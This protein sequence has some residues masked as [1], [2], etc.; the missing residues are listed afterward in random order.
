MPILLTQGTRLFGLGSVDLDLLDM[1]ALGYPFF[2]IGD[3]LLL[4]DL[5]IFQKIVIEKQKLFELQAIVFGNILVLLHVV[6]LVEQVPHLADQLLV[7]SH[8][9]VAPSVVVLQPLFLDARVLGVALV[10]VVHELLDLLVRRKRR[11]L[12]VLAHLAGHL[13]FLGLL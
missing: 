3:L 1:L 11:R 2:Q 6:V 13:L 5:F 4:L 10:F 8:L 7:P 9:P 12:L